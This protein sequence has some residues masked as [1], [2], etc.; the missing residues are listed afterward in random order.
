MLKIHLLLTA[1]VTSVTCISTTPVGAAIAS[2][3]VGAVVRDFV[4]TTGVA[5][6]KGPKNIASKTGEAMAKTRRCAANRFTSQ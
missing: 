5:S 1:G 2:A 3:A 6:A 4:R